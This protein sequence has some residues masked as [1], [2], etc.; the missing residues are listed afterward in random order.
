[1]I[2]KVPLL[3]A[4]LAA[5]LAAVQPASASSTAFDEPASATPSNP[6]LASIDYKLLYRRMMQ[7]GLLSQELGYTLTVDTDG[8]PLDCSFNRQ[9][10]SFYVRKKLCDAFIETTSFSPAR[11]AA[12]NLVAGTYQGNVEV[13]SFF[14]PSR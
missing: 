5:T 1:M 10:K 8:K 2:R 4:Q 13:A 6:V 3:V 7:L 14:Q 9:F 12:G 11:D